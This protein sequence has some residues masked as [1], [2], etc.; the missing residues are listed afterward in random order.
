MRAPFRLQMSNNAMAGNTGAC[1]IV[2]EVLV[3]KDDPAFSNPQKQVG[4]VYS[5]LARTVRGLGWGS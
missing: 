4:A 5:K 3:D 2:T 1:S